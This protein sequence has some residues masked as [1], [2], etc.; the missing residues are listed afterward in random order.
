MVIRVL[1]KAPGRKKRSVPFFAIVL[2]SAYFSTISI[3][4]LLFH[5][6]YIFIMRFKTFFPIKLK[7]SFLDFM[8]NV[9]K[10]FKKIIKL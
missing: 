9:K 3:A 4:L 5:L 6:N 1:L 7:R 10:P 2:C 8:K